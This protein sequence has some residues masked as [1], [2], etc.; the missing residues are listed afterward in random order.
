MSD[1]HNPD[2]ELVLSLAERLHLE[3]TAAEA[4]GFASEIAAGLDRYGD[5]ETRVSDGPTVSQR[6]PTDVTFDP[7]PDRDPLNAYIS[8]FSLRDDEASSR[9]LADLSVAIKDNLAVAGVPMTGGSSVFDAATPDRNATVVDRLLDSGAEIP[10]KPNR[11]ELAYGPTGETSGFGP[12][13]NPLDRSRVAGGSSAGSAATVG[14]G[15]ADAALGTDTGGSV[16]IPASFCGLVGVKPT[17]GLVP[18]DGLVPLAPTL[19]TIGPIA[20]DVETAA[21]VLDVIADTPV[22]SGSSAPDS[23]TA[24]A[25]DPDPIDSFSFGVARE[26]FG[27][28]V[29]GAVRETVEDAID[30]IGAAGGGVEEISLPIV[31]PAESLWDAI[32]NVEFATSFFTLAA[33]VGRPETP[34]P[35]WQTAAA[36][37]IG[38]RSDEFGDVVRSEAIEGAYLLDQLNG[39]PYVRARTACDRLSDR[40]AGLFDRYDA[41]VAPTMPVI[42]PEIGA[43]PIHSYAESETDRTPL[44]INVRPV[45]LL[46]APAITVPC[47]TTDGAPVGIQFIAAPGEDRTLLELASA[48]ESLES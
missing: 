40:Y 11:D 20:R 33:S 1:R 32:A 12:I 31:D 27:D 8:T 28:H 19:D 35:G 41:V 16:R 4:S 2:A 38:D 36:S 45:N 7:R 26:F 14:A 34:D 13:A 23:F 29:S 15:T 9:E 18:S 42:A 24:T 47:G 6:S 30:R 17:W 48:F 39:R 43:W 25:A 21:R 44:S 22:E 46:G 3:L 10:G 5:L 37:A